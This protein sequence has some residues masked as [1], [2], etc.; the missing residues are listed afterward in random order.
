MATLA[1]HVVVHLPDCG[2]FQSCVPDVSC[3]TAGE[4]LHNH[5]SREI[6]EAF[7]VTTK[8]DLRVLMTSVLLLDKKMRSLRVNV[9]RHV[10]QNN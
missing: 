4:T 10:A 1:G 7:E 6:D 2:V 8:G 3:I 5:R 9:M